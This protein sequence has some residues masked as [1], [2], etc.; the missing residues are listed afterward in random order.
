MMIHTIGQKL[1]AFREEQ[2][3]SQEELAKALN[4]DRA[5]VSRIENDKQAL[6]LEELVKLSKLMHVSTDELLN[7]C[8]P[9][10]VH[11][12]KDQK[13]TKSQAIRIS[14]PARNVKKFKEVLLYIL[15]KVGA[16]PNVGE[17]VL[18]K[19]LYF[20]DFNHYEKYEEQ[21]I[22]A[23]YRK[24]PYGPTPV[25]FPT[26]IKEMIKAKEIEFIDSHYF[27]LSQKKYLPLRDPN[28][29]LL[30]GT[31]TKT[32][33][34][35]LNKLANMNGNAISEYSHKDVPWIVTKDKGII[36]Y[37][38]VFYRTPDYSVRTYDDDSIHED[39]T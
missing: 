31:E 6:K 11:L 36:D 27:K 5:A 33:D 22:G 3:L 16:R 7:L 8:P 25:E 32:I 28:L 30:S 13:Q 1:I 20:I 15:T 35:V 39:N 9:V 12:Q 37:E 24:N 26:L 23:T 21:L 10:E 18:Y 4:L 17:T 34:D 14:V 19:L 29:A 2:G 38:T